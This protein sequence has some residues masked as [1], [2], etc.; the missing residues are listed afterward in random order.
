[1]FK[2]LIVE[3]DPMVS[4]INQKYLT[5]IELMQCIGTAKNGQ[6][7]LDLVLEHSPALILLD[8][9]MPSYSGLDFLR[10]IRR[11]LIDTDVILITAAD[12]P[13][14]V[15]ESMR[16]GVVDY[17][18]KPFDFERFRS[19]IELFKK[20]FQIFRQHEC[21]N[22]QLIDSLHAKS[23]PSENTWKMKSEVLPKGID[24]IT[25]RLT[26][27]HLAKSN[28]ALSAQ[29][30]ADKIHLSRIT[31]RKYLEYLCEINEISLDLKYS[32][33][34]RPTKVYLYSGDAY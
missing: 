29:D 21:F 14:M 20:R 19:A 11:L 2:T 15:E 26:R 22:Q 34:G 10:E 33:K 1:L 9:Y 13:Q 32:V 6:Q 16:L 3:D 7:A 17:I 28:H 12:N 18:I 25:L 27:E 30:I 4:S 5:K 24:S 23:V 31:T 8:I